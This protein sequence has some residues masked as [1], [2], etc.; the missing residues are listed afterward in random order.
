MEK[1]FI[2]PAMSIRRWGVVWT[3]SL[4][5]SAGQLGRATVWGC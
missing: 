1:A 3:F 5:M 4:M 2:M